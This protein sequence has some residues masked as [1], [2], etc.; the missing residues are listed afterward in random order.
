[1]LSPELLRTLLTVA[2]AVAILTEGARHLS[3]HARRAFDAVFAS[4]LRVH[5]RSALTGATW[6]AAAML[7]ALLIFPPR[8]AVIALWAVAAG[9]GAASIAGR[10]AARGRLLA[11]KTLTGSVTCAIVTAIG[12]AWLA[13]APWGAALTIGLVTALAERPRGPLDDNLRVAAFAGIAA[14]ALGVA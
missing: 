1:V 6:L 13:T 4:L 9:D 11:G 7:G 2:L 8:A 10:L 5:E 12:A 3:S 14:W